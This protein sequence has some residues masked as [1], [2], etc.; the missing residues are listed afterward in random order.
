MVLV[1]HLD[2]P[3]GACACSDDEAAR[4][5]RAAD[6]F[7]NRAHLAPC[8]MP[9]EQACIDP[10]GTVRAVDHAQPALGSLLRADLLTLWNGPAVQRLRAEALSR[11]TPAS[12]RRC[13]FE[14]A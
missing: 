9:W 6:D 12:R 4:A 13:A 8:R 7:A 14:S 11:T 3:P 1:D 10:D 5:F 2:P